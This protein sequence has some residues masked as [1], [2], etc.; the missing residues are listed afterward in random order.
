MAGTGRPWQPVAIPAFVGVQGVRTVDAVTVAATNP[1]APQQVLVSNGTTIQASSSNGCDWRS[2]LALAATPSSAGMPSGVTA[3]IESMAILPTGAGVVAVA[4]GTGAARRPVVLCAAAA[5]R[6]AYAP[7]NAGLPQIGVPRSL[8][9]T[10]DGRT[11]FLSIAPPP[12]AASGPATGLPTPAGQPVG[13]LAPAFSDLYASTDGGHSWQ[14]RRASEDLAAQTQDLGQLAVDPSDGSVLYAVGDGVLRVSRDGGQTFTAL[15]VPGLGQASSLATGEHQELVV[16]GQGG[17]FSSFD[18]G[19]SWAAFAPGPASSVAIRSGDLRAAV[20]TNGNV[21]LFDRTTARR[22]D[23]VPASSP[24]L[25]L[26]DRTSQPSFHLVSGHALLRYVD[27]VGATTSA[28]SPLTV[29][30]DTPPPPP[31]PGTITPAH[32]ML[33]LPATGRRT[34]HYQL[35]LPADPTPLNLV[36]LVDVSSTLSAYQDQL[37]ASIHAITAALV[38]RGV[39][40]RVGLAT[41]GTGPSKGRPPYPDTSPGSLDVSHPTAKGEPYRKPT[42]YHLLRRLGPV[43]SSFYQA[44]GEVRTETLPVPNVSAN[45]TDPRAEPGDAE[46]GQLLAMQ[47]VVNPQGV[48]D[49]TTSTAAVPMYAV[50]GGQEAGFQPDPYQRNVL[51]T[52]TDE[53]FANPAGS[54]DKPDGSLD[55]DRVIAQL[56]AQQVQSI[57]LDTNG[58]KDP[59]TSY[60]DLARMARGTATFAPPGGIRCGATDFIPA[61]QPIVCTDADDFSQ[62]LTSV[63]TSLRDVQH[64]TATQAGRPSTVVSTAVGSLDQVDVAKASSEPFDITYTCAGVEPGLHDSSLDIRLRGYVV[65]STTATVRCP[66]PLTSIVRPHAPQRPAAPPAPT[67]VN[68]VSPPLPPAVAQPQVQPQT[69]I[70]TQVQSQLNPQSLGATAGQEERQLQLAHAEQAVTASDG[71]VKGGQQLA[72]VSRQPEEADALTVLGIAMLTCT[73]LGLA[74][75]RASQAPRRRTASMR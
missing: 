73:V 31:L 21:A 9:A 14:A 16:S 28:P 55:F 32:V 67:A 72:L 42:L 20:A 26:A 69:Q 35:R 44:L 18:G 53:F 63:V 41:L 66:A 36:F 38:H 8:A 61:G 34:V 37:N 3:T 6:S 40:L 23:V 46:E 30:G 12:T 5:T 19:R 52:A 65:A 25:L 56:R 64:L 2:V 58:S 15:H 1:Q 45:G 54:P 17:T 75:L 62:V 47:Q 50:P 48:L 27:P 24:A 59:A 29:S 49:P 11:V 60:D 68:P 13:G 70:Q 43:D 71:G 39:S 10:A 22:S 4:D 74:H 51:L 57:G 33:T 7:T